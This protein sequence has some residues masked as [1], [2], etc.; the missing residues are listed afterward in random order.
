M[1]RVLVSAGL[2]ALVLVTIRPSAQADLPIGKAEAVGFSS[3]RLERIHAFIQRFID[4]NQIAGAVTLVARKGKIVHFE[5]QGWR[6]KE[7][8]LPME[9]DALFSLASMTKPIVS[10]ALMMLWEEGRFLLDDPISKWLPSYANLQVVDPL[11][12]PARS[13][14]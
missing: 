14:A 10:T 9:K 13:Q 5:A 1:R 4:S 2:V 11:S 3:A 7:E 8:N 6:Y 12:A